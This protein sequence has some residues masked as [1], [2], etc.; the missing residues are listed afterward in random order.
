VIV[1]WNYA[2]GE[3]TVQLIAPRKKNGLRLWTVE[4]PAPAEWL[5]V[6]ERLDSADEDIEVPLKKTAKAGGGERTQ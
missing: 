3:F 1:L 6:H 4:V 2:D 5:E